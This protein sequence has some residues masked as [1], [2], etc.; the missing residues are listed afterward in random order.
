VRTLGAEAVVT[1]R[2]RN[3]ARQV[4]ML[5]ALRPKR[6]RAARHPPGPGGEAGLAQEGDEPAL[7]GA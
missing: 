2:P 7:D 6:G 3:G 5:A 1:P 4:A